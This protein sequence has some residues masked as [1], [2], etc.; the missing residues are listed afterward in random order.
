MNLWS[1]FIAFG[2][3]FICIVYLF[4]KEMKRNENQSVLIQKKYLQKI[5]KE[6]IQITLRKEKINS[7]NFLIYNIS[8]VFVK[9]KNVNL[10]STNQSLQN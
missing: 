7:Y 2:V 4:R 10:D 3:L 6:K 5:K 1:I 8:E 9:Q